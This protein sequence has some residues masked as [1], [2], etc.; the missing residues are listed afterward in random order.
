MLSEVCGTVAARSGAELE[1]RDCADA[2]RFQPTQTVGV[3][4][5]QSDRRMGRSGMMVKMETR[6]KEEDVKRRRRCFALFQPP[7]ATAG[8]FMWR[9][10]EPR[11]MNEVRSL[12]LA[13]RDDWLRDR[14]AKMPRIKGSAVVGYAGVGDHCSA[15]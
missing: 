14:I 1:G 7:S 11:M 13:D 5:K 9:P 2:A 15:L 6:W 12:S 8:A 4:L 3:E 10:A